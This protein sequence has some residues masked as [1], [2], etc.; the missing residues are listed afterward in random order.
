MHDN[1][2]TFTGTT[3]TVCLIDMVRD[4]SA[5]VANAGGDERAIAVAEFAFQRRLAAVRNAREEIKRLA[6]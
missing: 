1:R 2:F 6:A 3:Y 5:A 4:L